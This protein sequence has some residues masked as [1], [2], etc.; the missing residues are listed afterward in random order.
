[1]GNLFTRSVLVLALVLAPASQ[2]FAHLVTRVIDGDTLVVQGIGTVR[3]IG[4]DTPETVDPCRPVQYFGKEAS[5]FTQRMAQ[6]K[7]AP[8]AAP[9]LAS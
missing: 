8:R 1:M 3:L 9:R 5:D 2:I 7:V 4:V 6:G